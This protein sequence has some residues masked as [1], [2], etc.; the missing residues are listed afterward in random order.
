MTASADLQKNLSDEALLDLVQRQTF[1]YFWEGA[2]PIS[3]LARD[4]TNRFTDPSDDAIAVGG[5]EIGRAH[6]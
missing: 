4:R 6:V 2:H 3:G 1:R 5:S